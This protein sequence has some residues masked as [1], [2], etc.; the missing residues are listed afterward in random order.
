M[1]F[2]FIGLSLS[3]CRLFRSKKTRTKSPALTPNAR[4][5]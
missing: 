3:T 2:A 5:V 1:D 4:A